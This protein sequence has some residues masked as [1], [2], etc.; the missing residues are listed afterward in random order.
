MTPRVNG[1][2][3]FVRAIGRVGNGRASQPSP[4][5]WEAMLP[6]KPGCVWASFAEPQSII[7]SALTRAVAGFQP[8][9]RQA[10]NSSNK[11]P[12][13]SDDSTFSVC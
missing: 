8:C 10:G 12:D 3:A 9:L 13:E 7:W 11:K 1:V 2:L 6:N 4:W 5:R